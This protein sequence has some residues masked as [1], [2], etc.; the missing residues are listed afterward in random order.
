M[1]VRFLDED[2]APKSRVTFIDDEP[3]KPSMNLRGLA[4][5]ASKGL[6]GF[7]KK[8]ASPQSFAAP[9]GT[10]LK[11]AGR[12]AAANPEAMVE[13]IPTA[14]N[15]VGSTVAKVGGITPATLP[16]AMALA[17]TV[18]VGAET[19]RQFG[20]AAIGSEKAPKTTTESLKRMGKEGVK[21]AAAEG[22]VGGGM[23]LLEKGGKALKDFAVGLARRAQGFQ[24]SQ[25][26]SSKSWAETLR[27]IGKANQA[28]EE[29]LKRGDISMSGDAGAMLERSQKLLS[30]GAGKVK[31]AMDLA[32]K[33]GR[34]IA[35]SSMDDALLKGLDPKNS[36]EL[37]AALKIRVDVSDALQKGNL[38]AKSLAE[39]RATW[40]QLGF[41]D[42]TV[43]TAASDMYR[44]A[45]KVAGDQMR[46]LM[47]GGSKPVY[48]LF[49]V[50]MKQEEMANIALGGI[51]NRLAKEEGNAVFSLPALTTGVQQRLFGP[52]SRMAYRSGKVIQSGAKAAAPMATGV[53]K[54]FLTGEKKKD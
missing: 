46:E 16:G 48:N 49:K 18:G 4:E 39:L 19:V 40:G 50:G 17:G 2:P 21:M 23:K 9:I 30:E 12:I 42:K 47:D 52:A 7:V 44:K 41:R 15:A 31:T 24:K 14:L 53:L 32:E 27:K 33:S 6:S 45:W 29:A 28:A 34:K 43:G 25:L 1:P 36:D 26:S 22:I 13:A 10:P 8:A 5:T 37:A 3:K 54:G 11:A 20:Q 51:T 35:E 38:N